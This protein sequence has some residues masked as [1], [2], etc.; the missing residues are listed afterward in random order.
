MKINIVEFEDWTC[1]YIDGKLRFGDHR[2]DAIDMLR[3]LGIEYKDEYVEG[4]DWDKQPPD[5]YEDLHE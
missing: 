5:N 4:W 2:A 1:I 3:V